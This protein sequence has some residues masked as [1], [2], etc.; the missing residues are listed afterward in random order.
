MNTAGQQGFEIREK[1]AA[2]QAALLEAHPQIPQLLRTIHSQ[3]AK[4]PE[5]VTLLSEAEIAVV[6]TGL[7]KQTQ[8]ELVTSL[9]KPS[10]TKAL[11]KLTVL[12][13]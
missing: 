8:T 4:D 5:L 11:K 1:V 6:V 12:D 13:L 7:K 3:L 10:T 9:A 2:L